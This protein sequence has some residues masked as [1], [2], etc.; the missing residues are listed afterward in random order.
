MPVSAPRKWELLK[1][2]AA[3]ALGHAVMQRAMG[4]RIGEMLL[5]VMDV[6]LTHKVTS[7]EAVDRICD[8]VRARALAWDV[9]DAA[10]LITLAPGCAPASW[11][12]K[13]DFSEQLSYMLMLGGNAGPAEIDI[14]KRVAYLGGFVG[15]NNEPKLGVLRR[16]GCWH[17][18]NAN[19]DWMV[20]P[21]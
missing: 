11:F 13:A 3:L 19:C 12:R 20:G 4:D 2:H 21:V 1:K 15:S 17:A 10:T 6:Q 5:A 8:A 9:R 14:A 18:N 7:H 16:L